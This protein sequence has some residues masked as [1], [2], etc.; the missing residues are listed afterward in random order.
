MGSVQ[1]Q[2]RDLDRVRPRV[3]VHRVAQDGVAEIGEVHPH[4]MGAARVKL[5]F[6]Q[7]GLPE[8]LHGAHQ[9]LRR[10]A[11]AWPQR[12]AP[13]S[14]A[15]PPDVAVDHFFVREI[16]RHQGE[17]AA[18]DGVG[19]KLR[20]QRGCHL[21]AP[22]HHHH[23][24]CVA[25]Q[26]VDHQ[27][28]ARP[29]RAAM[30]G[31]RGA[32]DEG[33]SLPLA[34]GMD[35]E[36]GRLEDHH[37]VVVQVEDR[38]RPGGLRPSQPR[39]VGIVDNLLGGRHEGAGVRDD[40]AVHHDVSGLH[41]PFGMGKGTAEQ[42][43]SH[44]REASQ[45][46]DFGHGTSVAPGGRQVR[47][48]TLRPVA[49]VSDPVA[50]LLR[51]ARRAG[52]S[53]GAVAVA[54]HEEG[55]RVWADGV[56]SF[57]G[58]PASGHLLYDLA[59]LTKPLVTA[60][61]L[62]LARRD[63]LDLSA[64]LGE[65]LPELVGSPWGAVTV[66]QCATHCAGF[67]AWAPL[68]ALGPATP[69][70]YLES[71][72][73]L[74]PAAAPGT[75]VVYS[76]PG[77]LALG[78][79]LERAGGDSLGVLFTELVA[80][81]LGLADELLFAPPAGTET[82][83][84]ERLPFVEAALLRERGLQGGPPPADPR[85]VP[86]DDGNARAL[87]GMAGNA[88]L[89]GSAGAVATLA[90]EYL[91]GGGVLLDPLESELATRCWTV[92]MEQSRGLGW[93]LAATPGCSAGPALPPAAFGHTGFTGTSLWVDPQARTVHVLLTNRLHPGGLTPDLHPLRRRFHALSAALLSRERGEP[94][95][96]DS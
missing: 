54:A 27:G 1:S 29:S 96:V 16:A 12:R 13:C 45:G 79:A 89:F 71:L 46:C 47:S 6:H 19:A 42:L 53:A 39:P 82:A 62:L 56:A 17:V 75:R 91:P 59:S 18:L 32:A 74:E 35:E 8:A 87:G 84:G 3:P 20:L 70:G 72:A 95:I 64:P 30:D 69:E 4:L 37:Q 24:G 51:R 49:S 7:G 43:L 14:R 68:Y 77:F 65:L 10:P 36:T 93:Q 38:H 25:V 5:R 85:T 48:A 57:G 31:G 22:R 15:G 76:C 9:R 78:I 2:P 26:A 83:A 41:L 81:P 33:V 73:R 28:P 86:C 63:G 61:L 11:A 44:A 60:T 55:G 94:S 67:P 52:I 23:A 34:G 92:G 66:L 40:L 50:E 80:A 90:L 58:A 21:V 88:G